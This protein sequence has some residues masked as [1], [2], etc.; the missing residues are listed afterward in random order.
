[1]KNI[2]KI[3]ILIPTTALVFASCEEYLDKAPESDIT[4]KVV[5]GNFQSFQGFVE[6]LY[7]CV[8]DPDKCQAYNLYSFADENVGSR[9]YNFDNGNYWAAENYFYGKAA[10]PTATD[11]RERR[12]WECA[13]YAI[14]QANLALAKIDEE[15]LF[16]GTGEERN[17]LRGQA[18][19]F[20]GWFY[21]DLCRYWGGMPYID[22]VLPSEVTYETGELDRLNFQETAKKMAQDFRAAADL[23]PD[24]WDNTPSGQATKGH[25]RDRINKFMALGY[26]G[27]A[28]LYAASPMINEEAVGVNAFDGE[29]CRQAAEAFGELL[30][31]RDRTDLYKMEPWATYTDNF[32]RHSWLRP[33]EKECIMATTIYDR[34]R[35]RWSA[36]GGTS[37]SC[38]GLNSGSDADAP[39]YSIIKNYGSANGLPIDDPDN[40][41]YNPADPWA[42]RDPRFYKTIVV[43][44]EKFANFSNI[45]CTLEGF[46]G[47]YHRNV[48]N[49]PTI[50]GFYYKKFNGLAPTYTSAQANSLA[51][52]IPYLRLADVYLMYAEAVNFGTGGGPK[53][54][55]SNYSMTAEEAFNVVRARAQMP[56]MAAKFTVNKELFF[57][58]LIRERAVEL[59][60]EGARFCDLRRWNRNTD[61]RYINKTVLD[62]DR[63]TDG[64]PINMV[65]RVLRTRA[66]EK[67][68]NWLPIQTKWVN[69]YA[70]FRQ[71]PGW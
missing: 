71:N 21:F 24:H 5:F 14:E 58:E 20:R 2:L 63:G 68:H 27:K 45:N 61:P 33:G 17:L 11:G 18:L 69:I 15:G 22:K 49:P 57:E 38:L 9:I 36:I 66:V 50:S 13:W 30:A 59:I 25:N 43:D 10:N 48:Q 28:L 16:V 3:C 31:L 53:A 56:G 47:G 34:S 65:E 35:I 7:N 39:P 54:K 8:P 62:F 64:K 51:E 67:K 32:Y 46:N 70:G 40:T 55:A 6:Q 1:M 23:L 41:Q 42:N 29:L 4:E 37:P 19:F 52:Y 44:G 60:M 12:V 26:L